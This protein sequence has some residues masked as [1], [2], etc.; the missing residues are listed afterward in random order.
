MHG[1]G[2]GRVSPAAAVYPLAEKLAGP[3]AAGWRRPG[4]LR[5]QGRLRYTEKGLHDAGGHSGA[6]YPQ[7]V[8]TTTTGLQGTT[9]GLRQNVQSKRDWT[10]EGDIHSSNCSAAFYTVAHAM[11]WRRCNQCTMFHACMLAQ[12]EH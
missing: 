4:R 10:Q 8:S 6:Q 7:C 3:G 11:R 1:A 5:G 2:Y 9:C 12:A